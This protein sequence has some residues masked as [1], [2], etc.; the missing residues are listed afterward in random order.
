MTGGGGNLLRF[1][2]LWYEYGIPNSF[3]LGYW[4][5]IYDFGY[6]HAVGW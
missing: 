4:S 3:F 5:L 1:L 2:R 6:V